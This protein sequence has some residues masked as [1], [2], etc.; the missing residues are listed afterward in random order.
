MT[1]DLSQQLP[2]RHLM[3]GAR[4]RYSPMDPVAQGSPFPCPSLGSEGVGSLVVGSNAD[5][6]RAACALWVGDG[7]S[8]LDVTFGEGSFWKWDHPFDVVGHDLK[9]DGV[10]FRSLPEGDA[11]QQVVVIDP[12]YRPA[13]GGSA[14]GDHANRYGLAGE[15]APDTIN[16]VIGLYRDAAIEAWRV[17]SVGGRVM[18]KCQDLSYNHRLHL[19]T[20]D[21]LRAITGVGFDLV[22]QFIL[23]TTSGSRRGAQERA[24]RKHSVLWVAVKYE[25]ILQPKDT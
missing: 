12:P 22:D 20:M 5:L 8:V 3:K 11:T 9:T 7:E 6:M 17:L 23:G 16:D 21:V 13:H 15:S 14:T 18:V 19:V 2:R 4:G 10:N 25:P 1:D 24:H